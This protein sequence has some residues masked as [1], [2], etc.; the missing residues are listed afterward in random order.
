MEGSFSAVSKLIL[1]VNNKYSFCRVFNTLQ[2][3]RT[4]APLQTQNYHKITQ[5]SR[6]N[7]E[8]VSV[9]CFKRMCQN[10]AMKG[11]STIV[12][13]YSNTNQKRKYYR[14]ILPLIS[15]PVYVAVVVV[16][17]QAVGVVLG[18]QLSSHR[19]L[20][21]EHEAREPGRGIYW[22]GRPMREWGGGWSQI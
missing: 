16:V 11:C 5:S 14:K 19:R 6:Q 15:S 22:P 18:L 3:V 2:D 21:A 7:V 4:S 13:L 17:V 8:H 20:L 12:P 10:V 9:K 1:Q